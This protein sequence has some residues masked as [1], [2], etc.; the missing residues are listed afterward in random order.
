MFQKYRRIRKI[1]PYITEKKELVEDLNGLS[2]APE[3]ILPVGKPPD[4]SQ[5][6]LIHHNFDNS[7]AMVI[8]SSPPVPEEPGKLTDNL[9]G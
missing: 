6:R 4:E 8:K 5:K 1:L 7:N 9:R 2:Y 3:L